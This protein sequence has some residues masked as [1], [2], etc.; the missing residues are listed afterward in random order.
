VPWLTQV[1]GLGT[2]ATYDTVVKNA[3]LGVPA[4]QDIASYSSVLD[5]T[6]LQIPNVVV[7]SL[8]GQAAINN[9]ALSTP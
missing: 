7:D 6:E 3:I 9:L 4:V 8:Y 5:G 2:Q 1:I